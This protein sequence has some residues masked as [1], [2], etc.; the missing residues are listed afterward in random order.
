VTEGRDTGV[1]SVRGTD[2]SGSHAMGPGQMISIQRGLVTKL[3]AA[4]DQLDAYVK[5][6]ITI[7]EHAETCSAIAHLLAW[8]KRD[9][10]LLDDRLMEDVERELKRLRPLRDALRSVL[11]PAL[12]GGVD[13]REPIRR[14]DENLQAAR[15]ASGIVR[16]PSQDA[17]VT[18][19]TDTIFRKVDDLIDDVQ[20]ISEDCKSQAEDLLASIRSKVNAI[21]EID[22]Y[23]RL[24][25]AGPPVDTRPKPVS[26]SET[27]QTRF[28]SPN[29]RTQT[30]VAVTGTSTGTTRSE[31]SRP[32]EG[33]I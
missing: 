9:K 17:D 8:P 23:R 13:L 22:M 26:D 5:A 16:N 27:A 11:Q 6:Y 24:E 3:Q 29:E 28:T 2:F 15:R 19:A 32:W 21:F 25:E 10:T 33:G 4:Q 18:E 31:S 12:D 20:A 1:A 7:R 14:H 30:P